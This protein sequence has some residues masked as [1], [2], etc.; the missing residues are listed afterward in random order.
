MGSRRKITIDSD[1]L[2]RLIQ[3]RAESLNILQKANQ[4]SKQKMLGEKEFEQKVQDVLK[5]REAV[6]KRRLRIESYGGEQTY[7][8]SIK[9]HTDSDSEDGWMTTY[10]DVVT[11]LLTLF[12]LLYASSTLDIQKFQN[13]RESINEGLSGKM[14]E[15]PTTEEIK[16]T[17]AGVLNTAKNEKDVQIT[18]ENGGVKFEFNS[19]SFY[20][21]G[22]ADIKPSAIPLLESFSESLKQYQGSSYY[23]EIEGHT[24]NIP[25]NTGRYPSNWE[26]STARATNLVRF[27][28][29]RGIPPQMLRAAGYADSKPKLPNNDLTG[30][31][32]PE[33]QAA[34]RRVVIYIRAEQ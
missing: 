25:I 23:I 24:D 11:L 30:N 13:L 21:L 22:S 16:E 17:L 26:L 33:N 9:A 2:E 32:I 20:D 31:P 15:N 28:I 19:S 29:E 3:E 18:L 10:S 1:L 4:T 12:V 34:N 8:R 5:E 27:F 7:Y 6:L 14:I